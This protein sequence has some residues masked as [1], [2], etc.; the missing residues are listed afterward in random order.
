MI[1][2]KKVSILSE[3][4]DF[5]KIAR[6]ERLLDYVYLDMNKSRFE[7]RAVMAFEGMVKM[8]RCQS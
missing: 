5:M 8:E 4:Q 1:T 3:K 6:G 2:V 7:E